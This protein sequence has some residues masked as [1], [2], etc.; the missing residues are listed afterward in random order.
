MHAAGLCVGGA[1][2]TPEELE[3]R[4]LKAVAEIPDPP[5]AVPGVPAPP[6][7]SISIGTVDLLAF[8]VDP[9]SR[10]S[11]LATQTEKV[12]RCTTYQEYELCRVIT[13]ALSYPDIH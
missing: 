11:S 4:L 10:V 13:I 2:D 7:K 1:I 12:K 3:E 5:A 9:A 8:G 6:P